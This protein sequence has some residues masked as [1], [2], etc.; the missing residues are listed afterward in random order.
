PKPDHHAVERG[1]CRGFAAAFHTL[2]EAVLPP[3]HHQ[4][5]QTHG[6][7][8]AE[9]PLLAACEKL[10]QI[11]A[12]RPA[13]P[14]DDQV[15]ADANGFAISAIATAAKLMQRSDWLQQAKQA[16]GAVLNANRRDGLLYHSSP[17][18]TTNAISTVDDYAS[19]GL[20]GIALACAEDNPEMLDFVRTMADDMLSRFQSSSGIFMQSADDPVSPFAAGPLVYDQPVPSGNALAAGFLSQLGQLLGAPR[21]RDAALQAI[22][23]LGSSLNAEFMGMSALLNA[24]EDL[25]DPIEVHWAPADFDAQTIAWAAAPLGALIVGPRLRS[26][27]M[28]DICSEMTGGGILIC[29][30]ES[31]GMVER[32]RSGA[33]SALRN[34]RRIA[35]Q[36]GG[37]TLS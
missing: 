29:R 4:S 8:A 21:Y 22:T 37:E 13:P 7:A 25:I 10:R 36:E 5:R 19:L 2:R 15:L 28:T 24:Y 27:F 1:G 14:R 17:S 34:A 33:I 6:D 16:Y 23:A 9:A 26:A 11:R 30:D 3:Q 32:T 31:C 18:A 12:M 35:V 20:A